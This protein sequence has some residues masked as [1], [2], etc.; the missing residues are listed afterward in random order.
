MVAASNPAT[1]RARR[2]RLIST[3]STGPVA[4]SPKPGPAPTGGLLDRPSVAALLGRRSQ[5]Q[6]LGERPHATQGQLVL[7]LLVL[8]A[9]VPFAGPPRLGLG[10]R[11]STAEHGCRIRRRGGAEQGQR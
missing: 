11:I 2:S 5:L 9:E 7:E 1:A 3:S 4:S 10:G 8:V 6:Q